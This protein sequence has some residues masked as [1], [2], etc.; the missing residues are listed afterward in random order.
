MQRKYVTSLD[1]LIKG[2]GLIKKIQ[3]LVTYTWVQMCNLKLSRPQNKPD[4][5]N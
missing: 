3:W 1:L 2:G 5:H 4:K